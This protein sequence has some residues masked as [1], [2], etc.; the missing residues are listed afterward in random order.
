MIENLVTAVAIGLS[1]FLLGRFVISR[2]G[3]VSGARARAA[4]EAGALLLDVRTPA[5]FAAGTIPG[6]KNIPIA[7]LEDRLAELD[8]GREI[9]VFCASGMR[10]ARAAA[11]LGRRGFKAL[12][13]GP[14]SAW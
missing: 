12:D 8:R 4:V 6:A 10:S 5:E 14:V 11:L 2:M 3:R 7:S 9:V 1:V 13:L